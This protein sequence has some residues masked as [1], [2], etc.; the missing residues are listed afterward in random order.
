MK[1]RILQIIEALGITVQQFELNVGLSNGAVSKMG[2][3]TRRSTLDKIS[4]VYPNVNI[5]WLLTG[6]GSMLNTT[7][8]MRKIDRFDEYMAYKD[9]N[10][11]RVTNDLG[12][13][14]GLIGKS[15]KGNRDLSDNVIE[16]ILNFYS[17]LSRVWLLTGEGSMLNGARPEA[18]SAKGANM[19]PFFDDVYTVGGDNE[20]RANVDDNNHSVEMVNTGDW[21]KSATAAIRHVGDS[22]V[23]YPAGSILAVRRV[24]DTNL[25][26]NGKAYVIETTEY[27]VT[28]IIRDD[29][30]CLVAYSTN[31]ET[32]PDGSLVYAP[33]R[34]PKNAIRHIDIV[35]GC[36][37]IEQGTLIE[38]NIK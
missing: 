10:D 22:M 26:V 15:R 3:N 6:E 9:L 1:E 8:A 23:E 33:M 14:I 13:S 35:L 21:F 38:L 18:S 12:L 17:D 2:D 28:K 5:S 7:K 19:I 27:R 16:Q 32:H 24:G 30:D 36:V 25:L 29:G 20:F 34:I 37:N 11:N 31:T 4:I